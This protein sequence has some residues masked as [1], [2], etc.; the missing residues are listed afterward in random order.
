VLGYKINLQ[1]GVTQALEI[2]TS[3]FIQSPNTVINLYAHPA[4]SSTG[5]NENWIGYFL[6]H[7]SNPFTA[8]AS[9][10]DKVTSIKTQYWSAIKGNGFWKVSSANLTL[11]YGDMVIIT[12]SEDCSFA[13][14]RV[15][16]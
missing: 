12:V 6:P 4:G 14:A 8:L 15:S 11:N 7:S 1:S 16:G 13:W 3:G 2:P 10:L 5:V 9:I